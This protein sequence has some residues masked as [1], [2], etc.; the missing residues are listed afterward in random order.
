MN[1]MVNDNA[2]PLT[3]RLSIPELVR[4]WK[5]VEAAPGPASPSPESQLDLLRATLQAAITLEFAT[6]PP[7]LV[8]L[9]SI[10]EENHP[11]SKSIREIVHE[12]MLHM[13]MTCNMLAAIQGT[14]AIAHHTFVPSYPGK[15]PGDVHPDLTVSLQGFNDESLKTFLAIERPAEFPNNVQQSS[16]ENTLQLDRTIGEFYSCIKNAFHSL[17][18]KISLSN[19]IAGPLAWSVISSLSDVDRAIELIQTQGEGS[20]GSPEERKT[21]L[22]HYFRFRE[23][24]ERKKLSWNKELKQFVYDIAF[25]WPETYDI[26]A[27]T[28]DA[29][30]KVEDSNVLQLLDR[31]DL[32][33]SQLLQ[34]LQETWSGGGQST[35][36]NSISVMFALT[37]IG[38]EIIKMEIPGSGGKSYCPRFRFKSV[39][40]NSFTTRTTN[41]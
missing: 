13:S 11:F 10:K 17:N 22:S 35:F 38:R 21:D 9:W 14:P 29:Y 34:L 28:D 3:G 1:G 41:A 2:Q 12:E 36:V 27:M 20:S 8:A 4:K 33:Y 31:F 30:D 32:K 5:E 18:P 40:M 16:N 23:M 6:V 39:S 25:E 7:Y 24:Q 15:L 26:A 19:Q 37:E